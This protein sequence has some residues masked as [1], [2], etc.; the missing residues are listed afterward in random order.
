MTKPIEVITSVQRRRRWS[1]AE[2]ERPDGALWPAKS[3][4][5]RVPPPTEDVSAWEWLDAHRAVEQ[6]TWAPGEPTDIV[7]RLIIAGCGWIPRPG[8][9]VLNEYRPPDQSQ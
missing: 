9:A 3:V 1:R 5:A 6:I 2:K 4:N 7:G 8:C